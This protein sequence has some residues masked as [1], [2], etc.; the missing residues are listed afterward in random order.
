[1]FSWTFIQ[2]EA[3]TLLMGKHTNEANNSDKLDCH[4]RIRIAS[5]DLDSTLI[6]TKSGKLHAENSN[7]WRWWH[8]TLPTKLRS[9]V[10]EAHNLIIFTNQGRLTTAT[11]DEAP[12]SLVFKGKLEAIGKDL[13]VP[14][15][16]YAACANDAYRKPRGGMWDYMRDKDFASMDFGLD[17]LTGDA[18]FVGDAAGRENDFSDCDR[19]FCDNLGITFFTPEEFLFGDKTQVLGHKFDPRWYIPS[20]LGGNPVSK[21]ISRIPPIPVKAELVVLVGLPGAGKTT[22]YKN[23]LQQ[24]GYERVNGDGL[25]GLEDS[26]KIAEQFL[27]NGKP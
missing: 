6:E 1:M 27:I 20:S 11:G 10:S 21:P 5:F 14:F 13:G 8:P 4:T 7:D 23:H 17:G 12:E 25:D 24:L 16:V 9:L 22:Y 2:D 15:T 19:H 26:V 18:F 3:G